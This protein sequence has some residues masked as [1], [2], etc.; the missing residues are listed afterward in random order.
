M[1]KL[2]VTLLVLSAAC[3]ELESLEEEGR[4]SVPRM[5]GEMPPEP[6]PL[7]GSGLEKEIYTGDLDGYG[8]AEVPFT[9]DI[10]D[11]PLLQ[12]WVQMVYPDKS[13]EWVEG[14]IVLT[15]APAKVRIYKA[16]AP[17]CRYILVI[18]E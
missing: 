15:G 8:F 2:F 9:V 7:V 12:V 4:G 3:Q 16:E 5:Q 10:S 17:T 18:A 1:K 6:P 11:P 13:P 14:D